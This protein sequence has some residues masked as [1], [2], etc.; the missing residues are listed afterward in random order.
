[1]SRWRPASWSWIGAGL[2]GD[3]HRPCS[4]RAPRWRA[5][6]GL[7]APCGISRPISA[8]WR[9]MDGAARR[10]AGLCRGAAELARA[11]R[12]D[13]D[14]RRQRRR[15][16]GRRDARA[17]A[18]R[19]DPDRQR[20]DLQSEDEQRAQGPR[21]GDAVRSWRCATPASPSTP[22]DAVPC[23]RRRCPTRSGWCWRSRPA[24]RRR[25]SRPRSNAPTSTAIRRASCWP[26]IG[27]ACAVA[28]GGVTLMTTRRLQ[29]IGNWQRLQPLDRR[30]LFGRCARCASSACRPGWATSCR[31]CRSAGATGRTVWSR[32]VRWARD[33]AAP[34]GL[35]A[36]AVGAG[37]RLGW[38]R[39][40]AGAVGLRPQASARCACSGGLILHTVAWLAA[41]AWFL[42][43][44][45]LAFGPRAC[46]CGAGAR[47]A[48][49]RAHAAGL[50]GRR[51][52]W[53]GTD[54]GGNGAASARGDGAPGDA[55]MNAAIEMRSAT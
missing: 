37:D 31:G 24:R 47:G 42:A 19:A 12:R 11:G 40:V 2:V 3:R 43:G 44:R 22:D 46:G 9:R 25:T 48:G 17:V 13:P 51:I 30:R 8:S 41:E 14:L 45:G 54:L 1:M 23:R 50:S 20:H 39:R 33:A 34:A 55:R 26:P 21:G 15:R 28:S 7:R 53:R 4:G 16:R 29:R 52:D 5:R 27:S 10:L 36:G 38:R 18:R 6:R 32:Q 49:A 35:A